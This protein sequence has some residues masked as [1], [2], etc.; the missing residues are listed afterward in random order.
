MRILLTGAAG[1]VGSH[2]ITYI[3]TRTPHSILA[4]DLNPLP[5]DLLSSLSPDHTPRLAFVQ[6]D[7]TSIPAVED[8]FQ[9]A[10]PA[11]DAVV[12]IGGIP[13]PRGLEWRFV[14]NTNVTASYNVLYTA[15][16]YGVKRISQAS[17]CNAMG[18]SFSPAEHKYLDK[19]PID[20]TVELRPVSLPPPFFTYHQRFADDVGRS[21]LSVESVS[22]IFRLWVERRKA[23]KVGYVKHKLL[24]YVDITP[25]CASL[26]SDSIAFE[27]PTPTRN[28]NLPTSTTLPGA[29]KT[30]VPLHRS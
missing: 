9:K 28:S 12:H 14:H 27:I 6:C 15:A 10:S 20:E 13:S 26:H 23:D 17:S 18:M 8:L 1:S 30:L 19:I 29:H 4:T 16:K 2:H 5:P 3:L 24:L 11:I 21:I 25:T 22:H 7:L